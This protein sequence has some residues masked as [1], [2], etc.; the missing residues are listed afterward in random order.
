[1]RLGLGQAGAGQPQ[2]ERMHAA[3]EWSDDLFHYRIL[4]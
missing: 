4:R 1:V 3:F 2:P